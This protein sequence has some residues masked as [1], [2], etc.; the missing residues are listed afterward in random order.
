VGP[1]T[2]HRLAVLLDRAA[3]GV[4]PPADGGVDV[5]E[6]DDHGAWAV[7]ELTGHS[8]VLT[9]RSAA[10][11]M[12]RGAHGFGGCTHP[13]L[14]RFLAGPSG[15]IGSLDAVLVRRGIGG[16][17]L[18][19]RDDLDE[20][21][22]VVR[23]RRHRRALRVYGDET[24]L[25]TLGDGLVGR[26]EISV[27]LLESSPAGRGVGRRLVLDALTMVPAGVPVWAQVSPGNAAS[28]RMFLACGFVPI[29]SEVLFGPT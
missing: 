26:H 4:F 1:D 15:W 25:V 23:A 20:H 5:W 14:V 17:S 18:A 11:V 27:E 16:G 6:P 10:E 22:R 24:G 21:P 28:L 7:V 12:A 8:I 3:D 13:D 19:E 2:R 29:G 9:P